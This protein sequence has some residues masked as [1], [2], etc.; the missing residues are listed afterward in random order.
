[1]PSFRLGNEHTLITDLTRE[2]GKPEESLSHKMYTCTLKN[3]GNPKGIWKSLKSLTK[4]K[5]TGKITELKRA[6]D[7]SETD[8]L[9]IANILNEYFVNIASELR[10]NSTYTE[11]DTSKLES[12]VSSKLNNSISQFNFVPTTVQDTQKMIGNLPS[13]K[14]T[15]PDDINVR[16][17]KLVASVLC[18]P[19]TRLFNLSLEKG[20][21]PSKWKIA[22]VT[23]LH[24]D[25]VRD[26]RDNYRPISVLSVLSKLLEKHVARSFMDY[27]LQNGLLYEMQYAFRQGHSTESALISLTD[28]ILLSL[29]QDKVTGIVFVDFRKAFDVVDHQ[30]LM[31]KLRL[32]R[33]SDSALSWFRS[34]LTDR[35][36]FVTIDGKRSD[37]LMIRQGVPQGSVLGPV[38]FLLF[39]NDI[40]LHLSGSSVDIYAD[41]TTVMASAHFSDIQSLTRRLDSDLD[42]VNEWASNNRM[43]INKAK[44]KSL[45]VTGKRLRKRLVDDDHPCLNV[46]IDDSS[47]VEVPSHKLLGVTLDRNLTFEPHID[48]LCKK[49][50]KRLGLL[51]QIS[52]YLKQRQ[53]E[54][55]YNG[56][57]RPTLMYGSMI[58]DGCSGVSLQRILKLQKRAAR[59]ILKADRST[60]S[61][62][63]FNSLNWL[64]FTK[65]SLIERCTLAF[66]RVHSE[67]YTPGYIDRILVRNS[68]IHNRE[69]RFSSLNLMCPQY[70][71]ETE[72]RRTFAART[73]KKWNAIDTSIR[74]LESVNSFKYNLKKTFLTQQKAAMHLFL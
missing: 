5:N 30:L 39:V 66:K 14:A 31:T 48:E 45:L 71:R 34:Y 13:G 49:L 1:M 68:K 10:V 33:V 73:I 25:G 40:P 20:C 29:D 7:T 26:N 69:T 61:I 72:G 17:L 18:E 27:L 6:D 74:A 52:P 44:T 53:R 22:R 70:K 60:P 46:T 57:V 50:S 63:L 36:Q 55:Y 4:S 15:G 51:K 23:P 24:K 47:S 37:S 35:Q 28:Q 64:P 56:V 19:L 65:Q 9:A 32:Y 58:W 2:G 8:I 43:F 3:K 41:D 21:F 11:A 16:V 38:L 12:F 59:I 54:T 42:A 62:S 67:Y